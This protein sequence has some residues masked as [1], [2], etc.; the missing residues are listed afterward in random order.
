MSFNS[1]ANKVILNIDVL[2]INVKF[3]IFKQLNLL[4]YCQP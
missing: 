2:Y 3:K 4:S 1:L